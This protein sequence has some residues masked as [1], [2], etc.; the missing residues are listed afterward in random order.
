M[1]NKLW[2]KS[3]EVNKEIDYFTV[4]KDREL[5]L[6][7]A[8][9][10]V[11]GSMAHITM[12]ESIGL[13]SRDELAKLL[14][15]MRKIYKLA[16]DGE[17]K[18][19]NDVEDVHS[20]VELMLTRRLGDIGKK[21]H[22][23]RSRNDQVLVDLKLFTRDRLMHIVEKVKTLFDE[24]QKQS[25]RYKGVLM[26]GYT[27]LQVAMPSSFGLWFGAYAESLTDDMLFLQAAYKMANRNPLGSAAGYGSSFPLNRT[28][29][30]ELLGFN[31]MNYNVVYAQMGRGKTERNVASAL[32]G[33]AGTL[34]KMA[35]D[36]CLF[37]SQNFG[38]VRLPAECTTGSSIMPHKKNPDV[39]EVMRAKCN[40]LQ[41]LPAQILLIMNNLPSG[42]F[43]DL[44]VIKELFV[45][46][47][48]ELEDCL[49]MAAYIVNRMEVNE[50]ILDDQRYDAMFSVEE[51][52]RRVV[53]G[54]PFRDAY[55]QVGL[56]IEAGNFV[57]DKKINHTHEGSIGNLCTTEVAA[58]MKQI[59]SGFG[60]DKTLAAE[61]KLIGNEK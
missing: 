54:I 34:A 4:G 58:L 36:A 32:A 38:F 27:H 40:K 31:S 26:P 44:Q 22:S 28:M 19:E 5:D 2:E 8:K 61:R 60:F 9:Y 20:Q 48:S 18:I 17:L 25:E 42:Y 10:D 21:I 43:R 47:F 49:D 3:V 16:E 45:P 11:M 23:G 39:F 1:A 29:T 6:C 24:L 12:L 13:L 35:Y 53:K 52:N 41:G 37:N 57:P 56:E 15:E 50:H 30:T 51:V 7:L 46:A 55:K 14:D 33:V 59:I